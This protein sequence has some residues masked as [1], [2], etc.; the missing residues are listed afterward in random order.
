M[1]GKRL[2]SES[3]VYGLSAVVSSL[4]GFVLV[5]VYTRAFT[6]AEYGILAQ[7]NATT[8]LTSVVAMF[9]LDNSAAVWFWDEPAA[10]E[11]RRTFSSWLAFLL[12]VG[13]ALGGLAIAM[14]HPLARWLL[15]D[16][17]FAPLWV[18]FAFNAAFLSV[19]KV[20]NIWFRCLRAPFAAVLLGAAPA[21]TGCFLGVLFV[22]QLKYGLAGAVG[23]QVGASAAGALATA[24]ALR[25]VLSPRAVQLRR[26]ADMLR[27]SS[28]LVIMT[29]LSWTMG[30]AVVYVVRFTCSP[31]DAGLYQVG[32]SLASVVGLA[33]FAFA[34][35]WTPF[36]LSIRDETE[37]RRTY[38]LATEASASVGF[39]IAYAAMVF[40]V[41][42][43]RVMAR[44]Q[45]E[46]A[47]KVL[48]LLAL[49]GVL[50]ALP[51]IF[52]VTFAVKK[53]S[54]PLAK[55]TAC[56]ALVTAVAI[57]L[58]SRFLGKE[59]AALAVVLGSATLTAVAFRDSQKLM[60]IEVRLERVFGVL[61][62]VAA[63]FVFF[64]VVRSWNFG[65]LATLA[66]RGTLLVTLA[67]MVAVVYRKPLVGIWRARRAA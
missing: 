21:F 46:P 2:L 67:V 50:L 4:V 17:A 14:R 7:I 19:P 9:C 56:G 35:A 38:G 27:F 64:L 59:G 22:R 65:L 10:D 51:Q 54:M 39:M 36:A 52:S 32:N 58:L 44:P 30:S 29:A 37:A 61:G 66:L 16:D 8:A 45:Y 60:P 63:W 31:S 3:L 55:A 28:P 11:R 33:A 53:K 57:P 18:L 1:S 62:A 6:P 24:V 25:R 12:V 47:E 23:A 48:A 43:L 13:G 34:Q 40:A 41:P 49:N 20:G 15:G 26:L 42:V 5:P